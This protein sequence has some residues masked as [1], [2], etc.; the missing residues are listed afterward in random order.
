MVYS[1]VATRWWRL[2]L[3]SAA[4]SEDKG[5]DCISF[6]N[7]DQRSLRPSAMPNDKWY[8]RGEAAKA[9]GEF[10]VHTLLGR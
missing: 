8:V 2:R 1:N 3:T 9:M 7:R 4:P 10:W 5:K 6:P